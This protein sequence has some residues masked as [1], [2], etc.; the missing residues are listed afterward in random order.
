MYTENR[1]QNSFKL[2]KDGDVRNN[3]LKIKQRGNNR[4]LQLWKFH[5]QKYLRNKTV[6][7]LN[8]GDLDIHIPERRK[9]KARKINSQNS[10]KIY[11]SMIL[12]LN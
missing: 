9:E 8:F 3:F 12:S 4:I 6:P 5:H 1:K 7:S 11:S 10:F 2:D